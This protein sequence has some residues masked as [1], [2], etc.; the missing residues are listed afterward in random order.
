MK[1]QE[2]IIKVNEIISKQDLY[3]ILSKSQA[4]MITGES[5][6]FIG[7]LEDKKIIYVYD[8]LERAITFSEKTNVG[9]VNAKYYVAKIDGILPGTKLEDIV[10]NA[11]HIGATHM[12]Y[13]ALSD[14][15]FGVELSWFLEKINADSR[16]T[17]FVISKNTAEEI[18]K[19]GNIQ[20]QFSPMK[21]IGYTDPYEIDEP[22]KEQILKLIFDAGETVGDYK[23][24]YQALSMM[25]CLLLLD[26]VTTKFIP[27]AKAQKRIQDL[28]YFEMVEPILQEVVWK[29]LNDE[30]DLFTAINPDTGAIFENN[31]CI[32][33]FITDL[34]ERMGTLGYKKIEGRSDIKNLMEK[35][36]ANKLIVT[37]GPRYI[38]ILPFEQIINFL[39]MGV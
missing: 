38:G 21:M 16:S 34:Y 2:A 22:R 29:K 8:S 12:E 31:N 9:D 17:S 36:G 28:E 14:D 25:E 26:Y 19:D 32:Y 39:I 11:I 1:E 35:V 23:N 24:T 33:V 5:V 3:I 30:V 37:D 4:N 27:S 7:C 6:P 13:N 18:L 15:V 20:V 10:K